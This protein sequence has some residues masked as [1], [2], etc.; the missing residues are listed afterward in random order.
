MKAKSVHGVKALD[1]DFKCRGFQF[2]VGKEYTTNKAKICEKGFHLCLNPL[3]VLNYYDLTECRFAEV[4]GFGQQ[5]KATDD[6]K[7]AFTGI[8]ILKELS[9]NEY[10]KL[11]EN[12]LINLTKA[13]SGDYAQQ[14]SSGDYAQQASSGDYA[15]QASSGD[16]AQQASSGDNAKHE[17]N[18]KNSV[19][20]ACG[21]NSK[22]K[23]IKGTWISLA[24]WGKNKRGEYVCL[25]CKSARIDGKKL[26]ENM[27]YKL[28]KGKFIEAT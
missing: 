8:R 10:L 2:E 18:G 6:T 16:Y 21:I 27:F 1:K 22:I 23:G 20:M 12:H 11:C 4:E 9:L 25:C 13:S 17:V 19:A 24:E 15:K 3:D 5:D 7:M 28:E 14:A 26:K